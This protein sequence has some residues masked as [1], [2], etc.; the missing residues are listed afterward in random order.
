MRMVHEAAQSA[1]S[2]LVHAAVVVAG[3]V[4]MVAVMPVHAAF[5][6]EI[7]TD[8]VDDGVVTF[9]PRFSF[10]GDTTTATASSASIAFG[11]T[12]GDSIFGGDG[13]VSLDTYVYA[14]APDSEPDNLAVA[15]GQDLGEGNSATGATGGQPGMYTV[16]ATWNFTNNVTGGLTEYV[17]STAGDSFTV[18][19]NQNDAS[20]L[21]G[22]AGRGD[23]WVRLGEID[24]TSGDITVTQSPTDGNTF[25]SQRAYG[26]LFEA[27]GTTPGP[28]P[29]AVSIPAS[30]AYTLWLLAISLLVI[31]IRSNAR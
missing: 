31:G 3:L 17:V 19:I 13:V 26:L 7:D 12:G 8:G 30:N 23:V 14:Y 21:M 2:S 5:L 28:T 1:R 16:Y 29:G 24:Y 9:N 18:E 22:A 11:T 6:F 20:D 25:I 4:A 27:A 15:V 10:G